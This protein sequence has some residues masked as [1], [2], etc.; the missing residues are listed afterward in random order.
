MSDFIALLPF[1]SRILTDEFPLLR[2]RHN[3]RCDVG[4]KSVES[5]AAI[6][7]AFYP[8]FLFF[9]VDILAL[10]PIFH[11]MCIGTHSAATGQASPKEAAPLLCLAFSPLKILNSPLFQ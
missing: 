7:P 6:L 8:L 10:K 1:S 4:F 9:A 3:P 5:A 11:P 2:N